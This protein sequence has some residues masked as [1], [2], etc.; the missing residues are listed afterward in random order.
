MVAL[1][2]D[3]KGHRFIIF[4]SVGP[5][6]EYLSGP[7][8]LGVEKSKLAKISV[9]IR[10]CLRA[11][12]IIVHSF[13]A[14][15]LSLVFAALPFLSRK[16]C[17]ALW[18]WDLYQ[19]KLARRTLSYRLME[20]FRFAFIKR[21]AAITTTI[22]GDYNNAVDWYGCNA[23]YIE[24]IMYKSHV[25]RANL[26]GR[27]FEKES[28]DGIRRIQIGNS[29]D[30]SNEHRYIIDRLARFTNME[31]EV[32][33]PLSYGDVANAKSVIEYGKDKLGNRFHPITHMMSFSDYSVH[34]SKIDIAIFN[35]HRQQAMG[36]I[37]GL[38]SL[39]KKVFIRSDISPWEYFKEKG[40]AI[41]DTCGT[42]DLSPLDDSLA[43]RNKRLASSFFN[44]ARMID[45]WLMVFSG[46]W[47]ANHR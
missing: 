4:G 36:N 46:A 5:E 6:S 10:E 19:K 32:F 24:N 42:W 14:P 18:G 12:L 37:I 16:T 38:L 9:L 17:W 45:S 29:S 35:H 3:P 7:V 21:V 39:G 23:I 11:R 31:V 44:E 22:P 26:Q 20:L 2:F 30:P 43:E 40:F 15:V 27:A 33:A 25:A 47:L 13:Q 1:H 41:Y 34:L 8:Y 28:R